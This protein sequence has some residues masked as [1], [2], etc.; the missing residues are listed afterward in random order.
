MAVTETRLKPDDKFKIKNFLIHRKDRAQRAGGV[1]LLIKK[2][3][4]H[5][6]MTSNNSRIENISVQLIN[7][8]IITACY[9]RP[10]LRLLE[11]DLEEIFQQ[12]TK[13]VAMGDLNARH[14]LWRN[15]TNNTRGTLVRDYATINDIQILTTNTP[16]H[17][18]QNN[19]TPSYI[20][21]ILNKNVHN[22][23]DPTTIN[24]LPSDHLPV[25][26]DWQTTIDREGTQSVWNYKNVN[27]RH[28]RQI[29]NNNTIINNKITDIET[30]E[31]ELTK[32]TNNIQEARG[33]IT[34]KVQSKPIEDRLPDDILNL[35]R[36][37]NKIRKRWQIRHNPIDRQRVRD[38]QNNIRTKIYDYKNKAWN[39]TLRGLSTQDNSLW[40]LTRRLKSKFNNIL[41]L[42]NTVQTDK[43]KANTL[44]EHLE[45]TY[46]GQPNL[47]Q[48]QDNITDT[49]RRTIQN[50]YPIPPTVWRRLYSSPK[51]IKTIITRL[52]NNKAPGEDEISPILLK[53][54]PTKTI[55]QLTYIINATIRL[56]HFPGRW[57]ESVVIPILKP[58]KNPAESESYR[59]ISLLSIIAKIAERN[60]LNKLTDIYEIDKK[61]QDEQFG[62]RSG[63]ST[64]LLIAKFLQDTL[65]KMNQRQS[66]I[67]LALDIKKAFDTVWINGLTYKLLAIH[68]LPPY[69][70][71][72]LY[73][74][75]T[76]R[77]FRVRVG[78]SLSELKRA[79]TGVPQ[80]SVIAPKLYNLYMTDF[81]THPTTKIGM[82]AD[83]TL[84][85]AHSYYVNAA[86]T[87]VNYHLLK[88]KPWLQHWKI[89][90]NENK[91]E[92]IILTKKFTNIT[93]NIPLKINN[94]QIP[95][96][97][98]L[99]YLGV[100]IDQR[101]HFHRHTS[102][103]IQKA[104]L[105]T[106]NL[107][108]LMAPGSHLDPTNKLTIYKQIIRP[109]L[110][111][112][113]P[114]WCGIT[115]TQTARLQRIQNKMLRCVTSAP[116]YTKIEDLHNMTNMPTF[117]QYI[118]DI[119]DKFYRQ[120]TQN[121]T[122]TQNITQTRHT[123]DVKHKPLYKRLP[124][125]YEDLP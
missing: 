111:Y 4:A 75:M 35:I 18:P 38:L 25:V 114:I 84:I 16:T 119:S 5:K 30:L 100:V 73:S 120:K 2:G 41:T 107:Y 36:L 79:K 90:L 40:R 76:N 32:L 39:D 87:H 24:E 37:K 112:A 94:T 46:S 48:E 52:S 51:D 44:A 14:R 65:D 99:K 118:E 21:I 22:L 125:F 53:N 82:F 86:R 124:I 59:P 66:T 7:G 45:Q 104:F 85:Y 26:L 89:T 102:N 95:F 33:Q 101:L 1:A 113:A 103:I 20:D 105:T 81:P 60:L 56:Q 116:R 97:K 31:Q 71:T 98:K 61:F 19:Y 68:N 69:I 78:N 55:L 80:G 6:E 122:L 93:M 77:Q 109:T 91:C 42:N 108:A 34:K 88:I 3:I 70:I 13:I 123:H 67:A 17:Y 49:V 27:W 9:A 110:T 57:K 47:T 83:D 72:L 117:R 96:R 121:S 43:Q 106:Q 63:H 92:G 11:Q 74:Y 64:V 8:V 23:P 62:F 50:K 15:R 12:G 10:T 58:G 29:L 28:Y 54:I 115:D